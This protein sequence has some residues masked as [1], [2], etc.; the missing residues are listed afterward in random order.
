[1]FEGLSQIP[2]IREVNSIVVLSE[3]KATT[4]L[5]IWGGPAEMFEGVFK[6]LDWRVVEQR[7]KLAV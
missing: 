2:G 5:P 7:Q 1:M 4:A 3:I 6:E